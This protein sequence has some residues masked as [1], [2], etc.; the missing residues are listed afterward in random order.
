M[1]FILGLPD[2]VPPVTVAVV[3]AKKS[4]LDV[5]MQNLI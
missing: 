4:L 2:L 1:L 3:I 5:E